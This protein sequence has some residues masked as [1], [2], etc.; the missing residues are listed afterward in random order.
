MLR[1][2]P[3]SGLARGISVAALIGAATTASTLGAAPANAASAAVQVVAP[4]QTI[5]GFGASGAWWV[6]DLATFSPKVQA[7]A[8]KLLFT[9]D[10]LQLSQFRYNIGG[11]GAGVTAPDRAAPTFLDG[12]GTYDWTADPGGVYF[13]Q[14]AANDGVPD[15]IGFVNSAPSQYTSNGRNCGGS[16]VPADEAAY[17]AYVANVAAHFRSMG[18]TLDQ[19]S[20]MNEPD[21]DFGS[22]GQEGMAVPVSSRAGTVAAVGA[23]LS[24]AGLPTTVIADESSQTTQSVSEVP[25]WISNAAAAAQVSAIAHHTYNNPSFTQLEQEAALGAVNGKPTW[26]TEICCQN[27]AGGWSQQYDPTITGGLTLANTVYKDFTYGDDSAFQWWEALSNGL[28]CDPTASSTCAT[29]ANSQGW[30]DGLVY[31]DPNYA[32]DGNQALY[33]TK[34]FYALAQFSRF[35]RPGAVR[36]AVEGS[37]SG[38]ETL[39]FRQGNDWVVVAVNTN[40]TDTNLAVNLDSGTLNPRSSYRTSATEDV[41]AIADP[42]VSGSSISADLPADSISTYTVHSAHGLGYGGLTAQELVGSQSGKCLADP[43]ASTTDGTYA[44]IETCAGSA[45]QEFTLNTDGTLTVAGKCLEVYGQSRTA[46]ARV[47]LYTCNG[48]ANQ[49]WQAHPNGTVT[50]VQ[51]GLCL[52]VTGQATASG[53][54]VEVWTCNGGSNQVWTLT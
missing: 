18:I 45:G 52:D 6:E 27:A 39:V 31:Y 47:D 24:A 37:P 4:A 10:G 44:D 40:A 8:A 35:V 48:G 13:L 36:Y 22:C 30:N 9:K 5:A 51:S 49:Q 11:G 3:V 32:T 23:A 54:P 38:V 15:L 16:I 53:S 25:G 46:G 34:R 2:G 1:P 33:T 12:D 43:N 21:D 41:A 7:Q 14:A 19:I 17:G 26:A 29:T 42:T 28:G 50:G 20:P